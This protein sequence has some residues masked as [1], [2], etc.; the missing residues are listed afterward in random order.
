MFLGLVRTVSCVD[1]G[2]CS[3]SFADEDRDLGVV[4]LHGRVGAVEESSTL[5]VS[6]HHP[7]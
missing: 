1:L 2:Q 6:I 4:L 5:V 3:L 7:A